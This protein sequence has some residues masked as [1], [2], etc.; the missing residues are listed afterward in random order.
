MTLTCLPVSG[1]IRRASLLFVLI[2]GF[3]IGGPTRAQERDPR[4]APVDC[5]LFKPPAGS[6]QFGCDPTGKTWQV[7]LPKTHFTLLDRFNLNLPYN[8]VSKQCEVGPVQ[9]STVMTPLYFRCLD[10]AGN[11]S[12]EVYFHR[13]RSHAL[14][15]LEVREIRFETCSGG[16]EQQAYRLVIQ[17][18]GQPE[19]YD[20]DSPPVT[21]VAGTERLNVSHV[22][23]P[24]PAFRAQASG[25]QCPAGFRLVF[26]LRASGVAGYR[27]EIHQAYERQSASG[28]KPRF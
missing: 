22:R 6:T 21:F 1:P 25:M 18:F 4:L 8:G 24:P 27:D 12:A 3:V 16:D 28:V 5:L 17:K 10:P 2:A 23:E 13:H 11:W 9:G 7:Q 26:S 14:S 20:P 19:R 15:T